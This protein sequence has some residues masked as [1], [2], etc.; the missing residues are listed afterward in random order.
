MSAAPWQT[1]G[2]HQLTAKYLINPFAVTQLAWLP[3]SDEVNCT[4]AVGCSGLGLPWGGGTSPAHSPLQSPRNPP[5]THVRSVQ[6]AE[7]SAGSPCGCFTTTSR[8]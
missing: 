5:H 7:H 2:R 3:R 1:A 6:A 4:C 8:P